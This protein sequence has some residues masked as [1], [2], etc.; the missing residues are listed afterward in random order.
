LK[1]LSLQEPSGTQLPNTT[2]GNGSGTIIEA[3]NISVTFRL[4]SGSEIVAVRDFSISIGAGEFVG[5]M[6]EP[7]CGKSIAAMAMMGLVRPP[8]QITQ[9]SIKFLG[10]DLLGLGEEEQRA[11][12]G[13]DIGMIV[14]NPRFSLHPML[15][16]G[17]Q[18]SN[19]YRAHNKVSRRA[20][21][22]HA[23]DMLRMV[24]INDPEQRVKAYPHELS[25]G[26]AQRVLIAIA[27]SS[28]P[29]LLIADEPTSGLDVTIQAQFLDQMWETV[30]KTMSAVLLVTQ[31]LGILANYCD[32]V[33]IM[34]KGS[35]VEEA[36]VYQFFETPQHEYSKSILALQRETLE[37]HTDIARID[38]NQ[39]PFIRIDNLTKHFPIRGSRSKVHAAEN[40]TI[41]IKRGE[42]VGLVGESGSGKTTV[43]RCL[44]RL[45]EPTTGEIAFDGV[46]LA[47][48]PLEMFRKYRSKMQIVF[49]DPLDSLNPRW[50]VD[51]VLAEPISLHSDMSSDQRAK[52]ILDLLG[53][54]G[55]EEDVLRALPRELSAGRQQRVSIARALA[56]NPQFIVLD[57]PTSALTPETT[58]EIIRLLIDL[59]NEL[60][61]AYLF[62]SHD[63]T[64]V[65]FICHRVIVMYLGQ[66]VE[67]GTKDQVFN[68]PRHPYA[69]ALLS[70]H[71]FPDVSNRRV[72]R[73]VRQ[74]LAGEI[75]S[76]ITENL[77]KGCYLY[78][79][80]PS[81]KERCR[82]MSQDLKSIEDG[83]L[84]RCW[85][86]TEGDL[87]DNA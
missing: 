38:K 75:P 80:C 84:V 83:R 68:T 58:A 66:I 22:N 21:W 49:Q 36:P 20:A 78:G 63:L 61:I 47:S 55:L 12:R 27:L 31:D 59:S 29:R 26:M 2:G 46:N 25:S 67:S 87:T 32:R 54:V 42:C 64:T 3:R 70:S 50:T 34:Q 4:D 57:E 37:G 16:V 18:I 72:D 39:L 13:R 45:E 65:K 10:Q 19:V 69:K 52:R 53:L 24:G 15:R 73:E 1:L 62:I 41:E 86:V 28:G 43:G 76:P 23:I 9:G 6:G 8:G 48:L 85:R 11:I 74:T 44:L 81:Q 14:Q 79:R 35:L 51:Q 17:A 71:L 7:G 40:V 30:R 33:L 77:P 56:S 82:D 60:K 5:L